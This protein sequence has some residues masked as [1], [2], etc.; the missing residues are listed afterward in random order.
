[1]VTAYQ[2]Q[3]EPGGSVP[4]VT[5]DVFG[6]LLSLDQANQ[7]QA[8]YTTSA[9]HD[10]YGPSVEI[11]ASGSTPGYLQPG[12]HVRVPIY[13]AGF[14]PLEQTN[15]NPIY[16]FYGIAS[17]TPI[18]AIDKTTDHLDQDISDQAT[19]WA[20]QETVLQP[21][22]ISTAA[23]NA[24]YANLTPQLGSTWGQYT[25]SLD[26]DAA[27]L[28]QLGETVTDV[29][30]LWSF[31]LQ[32]A[33]G[34]SPLMTLDS[35]TDDSVDAPGFPI[36]FSRSYA[37]SIIGRNEIGPLGRGWALTNGWQETLT[38][39]SDGTVVVADADGSER[40][41]EPNSSGGY[42]DQ[43]GDNGVLT[44]N[45]DGSF[46]LQ[47][48]DGSIT[49]F[50]ANGTVA[51]EQDADGNR[52]TAGYTNGLLTTLTGSSGQWLDMSYNSAGRIISVT[53]SAGR[54]STFTYDPT[55]QLLL[56]VD[57]YDGM[58]T[59]Y[60]Y[61]TGSSPETEYALT[62]IEYPDLSH[63]YITY[64]AEGHL[65]GTSQ[66]GGVDAITYS[67]NAP[68]EIGA[69]AATGAT[70]QTFFD[71]NDLVAKTID[72]LGNPTFYFYDSNYDLVQTTD[73]ADQ[74]YFYTYDANGNL[75]STSDPLGNQT[76]FTYSGP[77]N[78]LTSLVDANGNET[79][80]QYDA[81]GDLVSTAYAN[82]T[83]Q[84]SSYNPLGEATQSVSQDGVVVNYTYNDAGQSTSEVCSDGTQESFTYDAHGNLLAATNAT[85]TTTYTYNAI[86]EMTQVTDPSGRYLQFTYSA[87][88]QRLTSTDQTG[89][90]L[91]YKYNAVGNLSE[92]T[93]GTGA[94]IVSYTYNA[95][96][97]L[98]LEEMGNG[99]YTTYT[100]DANGNITGLINYAPGATIN[101][102]F[103]YTYNSLGLVTS[104]NTLQ[105]LWT[106][107]YDA[108]GQLTFWTDPQGERGSIY[109]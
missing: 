83:A 30:Q 85:G 37:N 54:T 31:E 50:N 24:I 109:L 77:D 100:Y 107:G 91:N 82:G 23:W 1:M 75:T 40:V 73:A 80:Y 22:N 43:A 101:S 90:T 105:G 29:S 108:L 86:D 21:P 96:G 64:D 15:H 94:M 84:T 102:Q 34:F 106:Y 98:S 56:S 10:G 87:A 7:Y 88:G 2:V 36:T 32:Q 38:V 16:F 12:E 48:V 59:N 26:A 65:S 45:A 60:T 42:F 70:T 5:D 81:N 8:F 9:G 78:E 3:A 69:T 35:V 103:D 67:S 57:S 53:D 93:D 33:L 19:D 11:L 76:S 104:M 51:Y 49:G 14:Q 74:S 61:D 46:S 66:D 25:A 28:G 97:Q 58:V 18:T 6:A 72:A 41:F 95:D 20:S 17:A 13:F 89:Y 79:N 63:E 68:G 39:G 47:E 4:P 99:T 27:Y 62:S 55:N 44:E 52:I 71:Q 92:I